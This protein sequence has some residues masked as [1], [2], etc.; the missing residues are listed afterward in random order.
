MRVREVLEH[1]PVDGVVTVGPDCPVRELVGVLAQH[2]IG[3]VVVSGSGTPVAGVV[4]ER[5]VV[6]RLAQGPS[7][8]DQPVSSIM[9]GD[10]WTTGPEDD[11]DEAR[12]VM[13]KRR[14]R[15]VPVLDEGELVGIISIGDVVKAH[16]DQIEFERDQLTSYVHQT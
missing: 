3:A 14:F 12:R 13:T 6:R 9:T 7:V 15:H 4:S 2:N 10:V 8:L 1:K 16:I 5:D 11:L